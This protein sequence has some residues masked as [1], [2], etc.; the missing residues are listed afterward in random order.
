MC[1]GFP[2]G[3]VLAAIAGL[4]LLEPFGFRALF[5]MGGLPL[6]TLV[7]LAIMFLPRSPKVDAAARERTPR[8]GLVRG[9]S[10]IALT[11]LATA[12]VAGFLLVFG[13]NTWLPQLMRQAA[14]RCSRPSRS[15]SS[16]M[17]APSS[18]GSLVLHL[19]T[20]MGLAWWRRLRSAS[21]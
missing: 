12:N 2:F 8:S 18:A 20:A 14:T 1:C 16:S 13:L 9:R 3:G 11:L 10:A 6:V 21:A 17:S 5:A 7:P 4:T 19:P 15:C